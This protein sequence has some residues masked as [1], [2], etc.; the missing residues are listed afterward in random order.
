MLVYKTLNFLGAVIPAPDSTI[1]PCAGRLQV[2]SSTSGWS[3]APDA[4]H[5]GRIEDLFDPIK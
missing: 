3:R 1:P 2:E 5:A 4:D